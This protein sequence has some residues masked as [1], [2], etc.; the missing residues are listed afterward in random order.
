MN[1]YRFRIMNLSKILILYFVC[2]TSISCTSK[3]KPSPLVKINHQ[4]G[5]VNISMEYS[6]PRV[7]E[8]AIWGELVPYNEIWRTGAN[9]ST[10]ININKDILINN[11]L[12][13]KGEYSLFTIPNEEKWIVILNSVANQWGSYD[14]NEEMDVLRLEI[15]PSVSNK[16]SENLTF[17]INN[18]GILFNWENLSFNLNIKE[19]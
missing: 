16:F 7:R 9:E 2:I 3:Q 6:S 1:H 5:S 19:L 11:N 15:T 12:L 13:K 8:I 4:I 18:D 17:L 10:I 14:Y